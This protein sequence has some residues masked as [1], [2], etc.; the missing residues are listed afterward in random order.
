MLTRNYKK[1]KDVVQMIRRFSKLKT[2]KALMIGIKKELQPFFSFKE[3]GI[4]FYDRE[5]DKF[6]TLQIEE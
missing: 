3:V 4:L 2:Y 1:R 5:K 6:F